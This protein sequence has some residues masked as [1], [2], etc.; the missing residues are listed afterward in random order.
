MISI[1]LDVTIEEN[2]NEDVTTSSQIQERMDNVPVHQ[3][4][5][6]NSK[7]QKRKYPDLTAYKPFGERGAC[8]P[9]VERSKQEEDED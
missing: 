4:E 1:L 9:F 8:P 7:S 2:D 3:I 6:I 5:H